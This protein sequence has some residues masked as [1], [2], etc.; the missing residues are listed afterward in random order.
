MAKV[1]YYRNTSSKMQVMNLNSGRAIRPLP[2]EYIRLE[3][4]EASSVEVLAKVA[5]GAG[6]VHVR[7]APD[8]KTND[9]PIAAP[10]KTAKKETTTNG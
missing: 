8:V 3:D 1:N 9:A 7:E 2:G 4:A 6:V 5:T 10:V